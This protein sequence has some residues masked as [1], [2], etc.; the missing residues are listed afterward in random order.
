MDTVT[1]GARED[2]LGLPIQIEKNEATLDLP[3]FFTRFSSPTNTFSPPPS[4]RNT[5]T[6]AAGRVAGGAV[7]RL[8]VWAHRGTES[9]RLY[10]P[11]EG[12]QVLGL[13]HPP[14]VEKRCALNE[15]TQLS[16]GRAAVSP[17]CPPSIAEGLACRTFRF[18]L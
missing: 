12:P 9:R 13:F 5:H 18:V 3:N 10:A 15:I 2:R 4:P 1:P 17:M 11:H 7:S 6:P 8:A 14:I 16:V